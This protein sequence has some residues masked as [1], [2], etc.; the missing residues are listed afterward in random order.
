VNG[1]HLVVMHLVRGHE[2]DPEMVMVLVV[3][4]EEAARQKLL[5][6]SMQPKHFGTAADTSAS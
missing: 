2:A 1:V 6:S 4:I 3:P 5:A